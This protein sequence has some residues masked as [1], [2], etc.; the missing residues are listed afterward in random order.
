MTNVVAGEYFT[1]SGDI[2]CLVYVIFTDL[3]KAQAKLSQISLKLKLESF[4]IHYRTR[5]WMRN[6]IGNKRQHVPVNGALS[7]LISVESGFP[8][9]TLL[10]PLLSCFM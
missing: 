5:S 2:N 10:S 6:S 9:S 8:Q 7:I 3:S 4:G 1:A